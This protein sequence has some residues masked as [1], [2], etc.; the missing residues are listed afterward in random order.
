MSKMITIACKLPHGYRLELG[1]VGDENHRVVLLR[2]ANSNPLG[3]GYAFTQVAADFWEAWVKS[4]MWLP[5]L[6]TSMLFA[7]PT[8]KDSAAMAK[9]F[10]TD[11]STRTGL[12]AIDP[13]K[14]PK[15]FEIEPDLEHLRITRRD[16]GIRAPG[17]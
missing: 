10:D 6:K 4:H 8:E 12:E 11:S 9:E 7:V 1:N 13:E 2:G 17:V 5:A 14:P 16:K 3:T 15:E